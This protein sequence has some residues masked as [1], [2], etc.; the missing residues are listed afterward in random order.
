MTSAPETHFNFWLGRWHVTWEGG[1]GTNT[2]TPILDGRVIQEQFDCPQLQGISHSVY[3]PH[4]QRWHQTWVDNQG[5]YLDF[6]GQLEEDGRMILGR[7]ALY[8]GKTFQQR[9]VFQDIQEN[10]FEW[11]WQRSTDDGRTWETQW[12]ISYRRQSP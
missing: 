11:H 3:N 6:T 1:G 7:T 5:S 8:E 4:T 12:H 10:S 9:M 2:I